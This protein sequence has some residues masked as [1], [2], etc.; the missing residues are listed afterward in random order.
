MNDS[1]KKRKK[2]HQISIQ[3]T[4]FRYQSSSAFW[5]G[6]LLPW[7]SII[8]CV[9][10]FKLITKTSCD[11]NFTE[12]TKSKSCLEFKSTRKYILFSHI[13]Q[14]ISWLSSRCWFQWA[15]KPTSRCKIV[16]RKENKK[17]C[18]WSMFSEIYL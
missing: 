1:R 5:N 10:C 4:N 2:N 6:I 15:N 14:L 3:N 16:P 17:M 18:D 13:L 11:I 12:A 7:R 9:L 8:N